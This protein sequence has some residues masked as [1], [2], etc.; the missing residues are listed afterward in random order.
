MSDTAGIAA[1]SKSGSFGSTSTGLL[2]GVKSQQPEAWS[3][4]VDVYSPLVYG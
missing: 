2:A 1:A 3:R 4:L